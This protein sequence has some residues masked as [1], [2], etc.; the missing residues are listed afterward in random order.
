MNKSVLIGILTAG[1]IA[2]TSWKVSASLIIPD[3]NPSGASVT[4][5]ISS[6]IT[7][8]TG[9]SV[10]LEISSGYNGDLFVYL[11]H[12]G[13]ISILLNRTGR[14]AS[15][16]S[17]YADSGFN[18]V[19]SDA[20]PNG[21]IH[22]YQNV[23]TPPPGSPLT[24]IWQPDARAADPDLVTDA[25]GRS[26]Y[27]NVFNGMPASGDWTLYLADLSSGDTSVLE[28]WS[29]QIDGT[30]TVVPEPSTVFSGLGALCM[31]GLAAWRSRKN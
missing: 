14:T 25:S 30:I 8:I 15:D 1:V 16:S 27:L 17:G 31:I 11:R 29:L 28:N 4:Q 19:F 5:I 13:A 18:V 3:G 22:L 23:V 24:G 6:P 2:Q 9:V 20:A 7:S 21:D 12:G 10:N 26:A